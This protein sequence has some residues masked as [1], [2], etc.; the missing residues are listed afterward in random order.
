V[1]CQ[2]ALTD[3]DQVLHDLYDTVYLPPVRPV[4]TRVDDLPDPISDG[5]CRSSP[6]CDH[7]LHVSATYLVAR[8]NLRPRSLLLVPPGQ[9]LVVYV[10]WEA[11]PCAYGSVL[12][13]MSWWEWRRTLKA[14][15]L[16]VS[17][18]MVRRTSVSEMNRSRNRVHSS[19]RVR[20]KLDR[21]DFCGYMCTNFRSSIGRPARRPARN[22][23]S[24]NWF[25]RCNRRHAQKWQ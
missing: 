13:A 9:R 4:V 7:F 6:P 2:A 8:W 20:G 3:A 16:V 24:E 25:S 5:H 18:R 22:R 10:G 17:A 12:H 14:S 19:C 21:E 15:I 11:Q 23:P 1:H